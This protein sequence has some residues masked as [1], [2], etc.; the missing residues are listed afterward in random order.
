MDDLLFAQEFKRLKDLDGKPPNQTECDTL[1]FIVL[2]KLI[3]VDREQLKWD[4]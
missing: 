2:Y 3:Q 1:E 4:Y